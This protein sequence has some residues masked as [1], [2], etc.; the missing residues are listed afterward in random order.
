V[1]IVEDDPRI[2][3]L[4]KLHLGDIGLR[5]EAASNGSRGLKRA[6]EAEYRLIILDLMLPG[7]NGFEVCK[8]IREQRKTPVLMLTARSEELDKVLGLELGADDYITKPFSI[9]EL[10]ARI[11][12]ILRRTED[13]GPGTSVE[14]EE[15]IRHGE[16]RIDLE[17]RLVFLGERSVELTAKE[18]DLLVLF[19]R[20]PGRAY[21]RQQ[22]LDLVWGYQF[23]GYQHTV[24]SHINRLRGKIERDPS[25][26]EYIKTVWGFGYRFAGSSEPP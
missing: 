26:P 8:K 14:A 25:N 4:L 7:L 9:R 6:L 20:N 16:L 21:D 23:E 24:N 19:A 12:A 3:E 15:Q 1:L 10:L 17:K 18:Y 5:A 13:Y 11:K 22:L 2:V